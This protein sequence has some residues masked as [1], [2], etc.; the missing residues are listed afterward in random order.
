M[1]KS[2][3][4][5][6]IASRRSRLARAQA[7][8]IG[9]A[10]AAIDSTLTV[11]YRWIESE[12]DQ[13]ADQPLSQS[14]GKGLFVRSIER[15]LLD[16]QAD[17]AIHSAKDLPAKETSGLT[18]AAV[19][20]RAD[21]RDCL[22]SLAGYA[23]IQEL[24]LSAVVGTASPRRT[25]QILRMRP[26]LKIQLLRGNIETRLKKVLEDKTCDATLMAVAGLQR[27]GLSEHTRHVLDID[28]MLPSACQGA[29]AMQ[30]RSDDHVTLL[31]CLPLNHAE[32]AAAV[33]AERQIV[34]RLNGD[35]DLPIGVLV[36]PCDPP[37]KAI[38]TT[39]QDKGMPHFELLAKV[40][41][42]DGTRQVQAQGITAARHLGKSVKKLVADLHAQGVEDLLKDR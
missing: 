22:V 10:L 19:P 3:R 31:R 1:R 41:S 18:I 9:R 37:A 42:A 14:G 13:R 5:L 21:V 7:E 2:R 26:D 20:K 40:W 38:S 29:L 12:G 28:A 33:H 15:A 34:S 11:E 27:A 35:C 6:V 30:C 24:A 25:A 23:S 17:L 32:S 36:R 4:P 39:R 8:S 16:G